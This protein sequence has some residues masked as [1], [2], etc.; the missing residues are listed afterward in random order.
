MENAGKQEKMVSIIIPVYNAEKYLGYCINSVVSQTYRNIEVILVN[1]GSTD[2]SLE[3]CE[4]YAR[5][6]QR[7]HIITVPN[8]GVSN[9]RNTG[10]DA[11]TGEYV[12][13]VD[14]DDVIK[15]DMTERFVEM[16]EVYGKD[17][18]ICGF[19][20]ISLDEN[21]RV[22]EKIPFSSGFL[23][24]EC[25]LTREM[26]FGK[27][28]YILWRSSLLECPWNKMFRREIISRNGLR[29]PVEMSLGE[30]FCFNMDYFQHVNG[31][32]FIEDRYYCYMQT[33]Q[34]AL[35]RKYRSDLFENQLYL[36]QRFEQLLK[37][38]VEIQSAEEVELAEYT[39]SK[40]IQSIRNFFSEGCSLE[41]FEKKKKIAE[42]INH[43]YIRKAFE[44]ANYID[45]KYEW[46]REKMRFS[47]VQGICDCLE[48]SGS[49]DVQDAG[50][51]EEVLVQ[52]EN[53]VAALPMEVEPKRGFL[54]RI[55][56]GNCN[57]ILKIHR[58]ETVEKLRNLLCWFGIK[59][60]IKL[61]FSKIR[62]K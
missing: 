57:L 20:M 2:G 24:K 41:L 13:F 19:D 7:V 43:E 14:S 52:N 4:N 12:Q 26:F 8:A 35:T 15:P 53:P 42:I 48:W 29:F 56:V 23:G 17:L 3:I 40:S 10:V 36:I 1:D 28:A 50:E 16:M 6:D 27:L 21:N 49:Q 30:D 9:A 51:S 59:Y 58:F 11:A 31:A 38:N 37:E 60:T 18:V 46:I 45:P 39:V 44:K 22:V 61:A 47:D 55:L 62:K 34:A 5:I 32:V 25:V 54:N 33:N